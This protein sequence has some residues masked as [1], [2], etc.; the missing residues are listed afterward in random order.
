LGIPLFDVFF[1]LGLEKIG[2]VEIK[3]LRF[4]F[5]EFVFWI[6]ASSAVAASYHELFIDDQK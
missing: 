2:F 4:P 3:N 5:E 1:D 6:L